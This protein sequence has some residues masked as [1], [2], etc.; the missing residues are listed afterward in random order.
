MIEAIRG[1]EGVESRVERRGRS[2]LAGVSECDRRW[3]GEFGRESRV[4]VVRRLDSIM[5]KQ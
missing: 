1:R 5:A 3:L 2:G 4:E